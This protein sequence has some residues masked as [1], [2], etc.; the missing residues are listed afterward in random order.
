MVPRCRRARTR[1]SRNARGVEVGSRRTGRSPRL[2]PRTGNCVTSVRRGAR[3]T[4]YRSSLRWWASS[5]WSWLSACD[6]PL[7][8]ISVLLR[9]KARSP[10]RHYR[11][12]PAL[13]R[14]P[15]PLHLPRSGRVFAFRHLRVRRRS[16]G[17]PMDAAFWWWVMTLKW[18]MLPA[19]RSPR[20]RGACWQ[21]GST[22]TVTR[23]GRLRRMERTEEQSRYTGSMGRPSK[24]QVLFAGKVCL[25]VARALSRSCHRRRTPHQAL[26]TSWSGRMGS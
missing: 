8:R 6:L 14:R 19:G 16:R 1:T 3:G 10:S 13:H 17:R 20:N 15:R 11:F 26:R 25:G 18:S 2:S 4:G 5:W 9:D 21:H 24:S 23:S 7:F 22:A 12:P